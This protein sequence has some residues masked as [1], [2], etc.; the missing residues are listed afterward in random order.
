MAQY[1]IQQGDTLS[2]LARKYGTSVDALMQMNP[3]IQD[4]DLIY[5]DRMMTVPG[6]GAVTGTPNTVCILPITF[7]GAKNTA[8]KY[9]FF[10]KDPLPVKMLTPLP[11]SFNS[12]LV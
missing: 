11:T 8:L 3:Q 10:P 6:A 9:L 4:K 1:K 12:A 7:C 2:A 5:Y